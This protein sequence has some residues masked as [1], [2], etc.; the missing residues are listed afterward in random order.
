LALRRSR[1]LPHLSTVV[2]MAYTKYVGLAA[3]VLLTVVALGSTIMVKLSPELGIAPPPGM[4]PV[5]TSLEWARVFPWVALGLTGAHIRYLA[6]AYNVVHVFFHWTT[7]AI[8]AASG[9]VFWIVA[10]ITSRG[11]TLLENPSALPHPECK[12]ATGESTGEAFCTKVGGMHFFFLALNVVSL[13]FSE[14]S[15]AK[16]RKPE[17]ATQ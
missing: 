3:R 2:V 17:K 4:D 11:T 8:G 14:A 6:A 5:T 12:D 16:A 10:D 7:P 15:A 1:V 13:L 9:I